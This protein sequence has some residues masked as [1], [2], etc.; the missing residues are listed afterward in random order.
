MKTSRLNYVVVG[1]FVLAA[2]VG[3]IAAV[4]LLT[5]RT[6]AT[7]SYYVVYD[8]V[9]G[10]EF[11]S[12]VLFEGFPI[13][14][15][16]EITPEQVD[17]RTRFRVDLSVN[18]D[19]KIPA[20]SIAEIAA[21]GLLAAVTVS[22]T[23]GDSPEMHKPGAEIKGRDPANVLTALSDLAGDI[24]ALTETDVKPLLAN[25]SRMVGGM[26]NLL[27][28]KGDSLVTD[29]QAITQNLSVRTPEIVDN[30]EAFTNKIN[31]SADQFAQL[32]NP[33]NLQRFNSVL[34][35]MEI[36]ARNLA[37]LTKEFETTR[38]TVNDLLGNVNTVVIDNKLDVDRS[39]IDIRHTV[40]SVARHIESINQN[41]EG[42]SRNMFE[43]S[44]QLRSNPGLL[45][46]GT[47]APDNAAR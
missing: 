3:L 13:G 11:G 19:W 2:I 9:T 20:D 17:G 46:G 38:R 5:G 39:I 40:E 7:D 24:S 8:N 29:L 42:T 34:S 31:A 27:D 28:E 44:R 32:L 22:L 1:S 47:P 18:E 41:L 14:Q 36:S 37:Q 15:V 25:I 43:F 6:G 12:R 4:A 21:S 35:E 45:L 10:V 26:G 33:E 16:E 30:L 23:A